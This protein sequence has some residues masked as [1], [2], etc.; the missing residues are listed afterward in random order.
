MVSDIVFRIATSSDAADV[1]QLVNTAYHGPEAAHGRTP[2][3]QL[4]AGPVLQ[5][6]SSNSN[7][8]N[9]STRIE[10]TK[11]YLFIP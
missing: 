2:E 8:P 10:P 5:A 9:T 6:R 4:H 11:K 7:C 3:T 1:A